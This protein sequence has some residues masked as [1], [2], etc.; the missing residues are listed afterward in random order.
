MGGG[1]G[2]N[3]SGNFGIR[4]Q[5]QKTSGE[6]GS[7]CM[8]VCFREDVDS[9]TE[10]DLHMRRLQCAMSEVCGKFKT[11]LNV[12]RVFL[13]NTSS[14]EF[15]RDTEEIFAR[16][17]DSVSPLSTIVNDELKNKGKKR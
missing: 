11:P 9:A 8:V 10:G 7:R 13:R 14:F 6:P 3:L 15:N 4:V 2:T 17:S 16:R 1:F 5:L 12:I